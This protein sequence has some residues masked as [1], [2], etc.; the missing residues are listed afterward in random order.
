MGKPKGAQFSPFEIGQISVHASHGL[1]PV[2]IASEVLKPNGKPATHQNISK[3]LKRLKKDKDWRGERK[4]GSGPPRKTSKK[5]DSALL[6]EVIK[7]RGS[8]KVTILRRP[9]DAMNRQPDDA[10]TQ[11]RH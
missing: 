1:G 4:A 7:M 3:V 6:K 11:Q 9:N 8:L 2:E 5:L 10:T